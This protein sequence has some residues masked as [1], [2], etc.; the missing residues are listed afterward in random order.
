MKLIERLE[1]EHRIIE[2][3]VASFITFTG[4]FQNQPE[5]FDNLRFYPKFFQDYIDAYHHQ[6]EEDI[7]IRSFHE[8]SIPETSP[9]LEVILQEHRANKL[10]I[11]RLIDLSRK[12]QLLSAEIDELHSLAKQYCANIWEHIDKEDTVLFPE[13]ID[14][15]RGQEKIRAESD[16]IQF[17][18]RNPVQSEENRA[19]AL[20]SAYPPVETLDSYT[21]GEGCASCGKYGTIC[22]G[23]EIEWWSE[24]EW[25]NFH[26]KPM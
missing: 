15:I 26:A 8:L 9:P 10:I 4:K 3:F 17:E 19:M 12:S 5:D 21:R 18:N 7:L 14:R 16:F 24:S 25:D 2:K 1:A 11:Q 13:A 6:K 23:I 20:I 22:Q